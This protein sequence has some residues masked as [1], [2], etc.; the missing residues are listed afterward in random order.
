M[1]FFDQYYLDFENFYFSFCIGHSILSNGV[2]QILNKS[3]ENRTIGEERQVSDAQICAPTT[4]IPMV[5]IQI[6]LLPF[7]HYTV[8]FNFSYAFIRKQTSSVGISM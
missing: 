5:L 1:H 6:L 7:T 3:K 2:A 8:L 4:S